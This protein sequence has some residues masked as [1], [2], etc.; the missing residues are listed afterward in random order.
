VDVARSFDKTCASCTRPGA[1]RETRCLRVLRLYGRHHRHAGRGTLDD[2]G[3]IPRFVAALRSGADFVKGSLFAQGG[4]S[5]DITTFRRAA[6]SGSTWSSML[7]RHQIHDLVTAT[8]RFG[9]AA[10]YLRV[11][12][13]ASSGDPDQRPSRE[14]GWSSMRYR[15][16]STVGST[17]RA[18]SIR[19][20]T[21]PSVADRS[22]WSVCETPARSLARAQRRRL[23]PMRVALVLL[24]A[25]AHCDGL[26]PQMR[27]SLGRSCGGEEKFAVLSPQST[28][29][30]PF[31]TAKAV[32]KPLHSGPLRHRPR[33]RHRTLVGVGRRGRPRPGVHARRIDPSS[34]A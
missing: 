33:Y 12:V 21:G 17:D 27:N 3:E 14:A 11:T 1:E 32:S 19:S 8:T 26:H 20:A 25:P 22:P 10:T 9:L 34:A 16:S 6:I 24:G 28:T 4:S 18:I 5:A 30:L 2:A 15:A 23:S 7:V 31:S 13:Q 29:N